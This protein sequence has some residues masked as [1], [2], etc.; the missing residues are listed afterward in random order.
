VFLVGSGSSFHHF[1]HWGSP[2]AEEFDDWLAETLTSPQASREAALVAW[3]EAP[4]A[5]HAHGREEHLLPLMVAAGAANDV[6]AR[7]FF[8]GSVMDTPMSCWFFD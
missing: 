5:R 3:E 7:P 6:P 8:Q 1:S 4:H 2:L